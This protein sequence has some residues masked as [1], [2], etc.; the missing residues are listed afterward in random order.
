LPSD[1]FSYIAAHGSVR[2]E[3]SIAAWLQAML[4]A[5]SALAAAQ[6]EAGEIPA[7]AAAEIAAACRVG[8]IDAA[9]VLAS[10]EQH[11]VPVIGLVEQL[12]SAVGGDAAAFVHH[13]STSQDILDTAAMIVTQRAAALTAGRLDDAAET[14]D[15]LAAAH[16]MVPMIGRTLGQH[17]LPTTFGAVAGRWRRGLG[18]A[19]GTLRDLGASLPVQLGGPVG[20]GTSYGPHAAAIAASVAKRLGLSD[21][22]GP[23][24]TMRTPI[25]RIA[26]AWGTVGVVAGDIATQLVGLMSSDVGELAERSSGGSSSMAHKRNPVAAI[27]ARAA[28]LQLPGLISTVLHAAS[29]HEFERAAGAWHAEWPALDALLRAG[30]SSVDWLATSLERVEVDAERMASNLALGAKERSAR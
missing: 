20:D 5:E 7:G 18:E 1:A 3:T 2:G 10:A 16:G 12:R 9:A 28:A 14:V 27:S 25:A 24:S 17:A 26:G 19:A 22:A 29:G 21:A 8:D 30:G 13:G 6:A 23:W 15:A 11:G 4:D